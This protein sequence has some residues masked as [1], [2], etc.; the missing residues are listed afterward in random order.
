VIPTHRRPPLVARAVASA[1]AQ[2]RLPAEV[3]VVDDEPNGPARPVVEQLAQGAPCAVR[4]LTHERGKGPSTS[5]NVG[6][7]A[8]RGE[9]LAFLDDDDAWLPGYIGAALSRADADLVLTARWDIG[10]DG[11]RRPGKAPL[12]HFDERAW[13]RRNLGGTG[14]T[15]VVR[16]PLF[17]AIGGYDERL[18]AGEDRDFILR[19]MRAGARYAAVPERLVDHHDEGPRLTLR[20][21][22]I[23]PGRL[24]FLAKHY[25][26]MRAGD[27]GYLLRKTA[28]EV[29]RAATA[30]S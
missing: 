2:H 12:P 9:W 4:Y 28:R 20:A 5:R 24:R 18:R 6:A 15:T 22:A 30:R 13:L 8:A 16:R 7:A 27:V 21:R 11:V 3:L 19:A 29:L 14:S 10:E 23:L 26:F 17:L 25:R 1:L